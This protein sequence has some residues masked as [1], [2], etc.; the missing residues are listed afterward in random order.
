M[1]FLSQYTCARLDYNSHCFLHRFKTVTHKDRYGG[2]SKNPNQMGIGENMG[3]GS[4]TPDL[5]H[6]WLTL[7]EQQKNLCV[8]LRKLSLL[9]FSRDRLVYLLH[10]GRDSDGQR[11][12]VNV[13]AN[14][15]SELSLRP[16]EYRKMLKENSIGEHRKTST[17]WGFGGR[18]MISCNVSR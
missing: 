3:K 6:C 15:I 13:I 18:D 2:P 17:G 8:H 1:L 4:V 16:A 9:S 11:R 10:Q 12:I 7:P 5:S 14:G